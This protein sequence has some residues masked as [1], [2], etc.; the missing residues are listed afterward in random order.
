[1]FCVLESSE[2]SGIFS[3]GGAEGQTEK[4]RGGTVEMLMSSKAKKIKGAS[5]VNPNA[6]RLVTFLHIVCIRDE[7][8]FTCLYEIGHFF[9]VWWLHLTILYL[10]VRDY[11]GHV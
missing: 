8:P 1:L 10:F 2:K 11:A 5:L 6:K 4:E 3:Y 7:L 9:S